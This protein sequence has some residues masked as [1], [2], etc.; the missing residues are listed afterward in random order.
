MPSIERQLLFGFERTIKSSFRIKKSGDDSKVETPVPM[1]NTEVKH[2][3]GED[4]WACPCENSKL[5]VFL[6]PFLALVSEPFFI[7]EE[8]DNKT[9]SQFT[10]FKQT[11]ENVAQQAL[12]LREYK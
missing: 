3:N 1:P 11:I 2:F 8:Y 6:Y 4:S 10:I 9:Y 12:V 5:P 7:I